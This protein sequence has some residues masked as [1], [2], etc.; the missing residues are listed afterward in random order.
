MTSNPALPTA[1]LQ[2]LN[3]MDI[4]SSS[5]QGSAASSDLEYLQQRIDVLRNLLIGA[6]IAFIL[7]G[8]SFGLFIMQQMRIARGQLY[9]FRVTADKNRREFQQINEPLIRQFSVEIQNYATLHPD[10]APLLQKY[11]PY[12]EPYFGA[13]A[14]PVPMPPSAPGAK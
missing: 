12:L 4:E 8:G 5:R 9:E 3:N 11:R 13:A 7:V 6:L 14:N 2:L 10:F 1:S